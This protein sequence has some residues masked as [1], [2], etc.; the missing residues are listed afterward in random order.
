MTPSK[1]SEAAKPTY[2]EDD[3]DCAGAPIVLTF[4][5]GLVNDFLSDWCE[6]KAKLIMER[7][8]QMNTLSGK[9]H[10]R[11]R[12]YYYSCTAHFSTIIVPNDK[13][14]ARK[15]PFYRLLRAFE[16]YSNSSHDTLYWLYIVL[17]CLDIVV[18]FHS[19]Y[20]ILFFLKVFATKL[21]PLLF[22]RLFCHQTLCMLFSR[23]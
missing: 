22:P 19:F 7:F 17:S 13:K 4:E 2:N 11:I 18:E 21:Q 9:L 3:Y 12:K 14:R 8:L 15:C 16:N 6:M 20:V 23:R 1:P 5:Y 10:G